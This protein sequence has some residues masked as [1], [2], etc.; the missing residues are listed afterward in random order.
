MTDLKLS[1]TLS[2]FERLV[3]VP[4]HHRLNVGVF[5]QNV[6]QRSSETVKFGLASGSC[7]IPYVFEFLFGYRGTLLQQFKTRIRSRIGCFE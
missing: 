5:F 4:S 6:F 1:R 7:F 2:T 3:V